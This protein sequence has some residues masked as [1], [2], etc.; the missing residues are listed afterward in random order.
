MSSEDVKAELV[1]IRMKYGRDEE[2]RG[3]RSR[4]PDSFPV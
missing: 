3:L 1:A 4:F 2:Y